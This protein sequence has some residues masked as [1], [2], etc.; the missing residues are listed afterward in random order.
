VLYYFLLT[1]LPPLS[2]KIQ[3]DLSFEELKDFLY[4]NLVRK[5]F[6]KVH[7]LLLPT[8]LY[9]IRAL[10]LGQPLSEG[11]NFSSKD[12]ETALLVQEGLPDYVIEYLHRYESNGER[13][14]YFSSLYASLFRADGLRLKGFLQQYYQ[15]EREQRIVLAALRAKKF[16][17]DIIK[18]FQFEDPSDPF[19]ANVLMQKDSS[20]YVPPEGFERLKILFVENSDNPEKLYRALLEYQFIKIEEM[21]EAAALYSADQVL[22]Y[23]AQFLIVNSWFQLNFEAGYQEMEKL[24]NYG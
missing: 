4:T 2:F 19:I 7:Q 9:N 22:A 12:L 11:G 21:G 8:D 6:E 20:E 16:K 17:I 3:P 15:Y 14:K 18:E 1:A 10:W 13:L 24:N 23:V 5:D